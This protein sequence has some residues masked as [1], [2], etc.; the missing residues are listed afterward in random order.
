MSENKVNIQ[1]IIET[2]ADRFPFAIFVIGV[3]MFLWG[4][5]G[6]TQ[7]LVVVDLTGRIG[8][9][10]FGIILTGIGII[11]LIRDSTAFS[12]RPEEKENPITV[13]PENPEQIDSNSKD[14]QEISKLFLLGFFFFDNGREDEVLVFDAPNTPDFILGETEE[15]KITIENTIYEAI[16]HIVSEA[17][18]KNGITPEDLFRAG[19]SQPVYYRIFIEKEINTGNGNKL[20]ALPKPYVFFKIKLQKRIYGKNL[21][22][23]KKRTVRNSLLNTSNPTDLPSE[24][25]PEIKEAFK[26]DLIYKQLG[27]T[28]LEC[29]DVLIFRE[30]KQHIKF[31]LIRRENTKNQTEMQEERWEYPKGGLWY[32]ETPLDAV[33][34]EVKEETSIIPRD[35]KHCLDLG[36]QTVDVSQRNKPYD[37]LRVHGFTF[38]YTGDPNLGELFS[39]E[40]HDLFKW[41]TIDEAKEK[42]WM[43]EN[44]YAVEFFKR[45]EKNED[46]ILRK[47][48]IK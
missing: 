4:V 43:K 47:A 23:K 45:W 34:R 5:T 29:V 9:V 13:L 27:R 39:E 25:V 40:H 37:T 1:K 16:D 19:A 28:V 12:Q 11:L 32:L 7:P 17:I 36:W 14:S 33:Y 2:L 18:K 42:V 46:E 26:S 3:V 20:V 48:G 41:F 35:L 31:L 38:L 30:D 8:L 44:N 22:W 6:G 24:R 21:K 15:N 10:I